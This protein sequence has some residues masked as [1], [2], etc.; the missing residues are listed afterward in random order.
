MKN[1]LDSKAGKAARKAARRA[2][3]SARIDWTKPDK[4]A[5][6]GSRKASAGLVRLVIALAFLATMASPALAHGSAG[7]KRTGGT[8]T[9]SSGGTSTR[10]ASACKFCIAR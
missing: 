7:W 4:E 2:K 6:N 10:S 1:R 3:E 8:S 9:H 5:A